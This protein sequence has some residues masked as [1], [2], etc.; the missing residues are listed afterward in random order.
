MRPFTVHYIEIS[1]KSL[2]RSGLFLSLAA[3][4][5]LVG[6]AEAIK[7][8]AVT[9]LGKS[10]E[11]SDIQ[12]GLALD[13]GNPV[14]HSRLSVLYGDSLEPS[15][16]SAAVQEARRATALNPNKSE[17]WLSLASACESVR[18]NSC[19]DQAVERALNL[20]PKVPQVWWDAGNLYVR[21]DQPQSALP[22]FHRLLELSPDYAEPTFDLTLHAYGDPKMILEKVVGD[23]KDP[24]LELA[25][26]DFI[27][28]NNEFD[29]AHQAWTRIAS[30]GS[31]F[32]F[33]AAQPYIERL[34]DKGQYQEARAI[35]LNLEG[36]GVI[37]K[38]ADSDQGNLVY[39][40]GF[41]QPPL[42]AGFDW[43]SPASSYVSVDF[44]D[45][46]PYEGAHCLRVDFPVGQNDDFQP[47]YQFVPVVPDQ[48]YTLNA[49]VSSRDI[50]SDSGPRLRVTDPDCPTC[51]DAA[52]DTTVGSTDWHNVTLN[53]TAGPQ[54]QAVRVSVW[55]PR[56]RVFPMEISGTFWLDAV[57]IRAERH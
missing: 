3:V 36:R 10:A 40:G 41:E 6:S 53:F 22:C 38:P 14:L 8:A 30:G 46:S 50:T 42:D 16:L 37:A 9:T 24:R 56:S 51:L 48:A 39:N 19:A 35:W 23:E 26:A 27:S 54:T 15:N 52:T 7:I 4:V 31:P 57:S 33:A 44:A 17:Y 49:Y 45:A 5:T 29:A 25:F 32:A 55:R 28:A 12:K 13:P 43:R 20:S 47:V 2:R 21:T 34:L 18:D 1:L 11:V